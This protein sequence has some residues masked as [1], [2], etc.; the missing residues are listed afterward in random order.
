M[1]VETLQEL[2]V[3]ELK[4][5]YSAEK[6]ITKALPKLAK[7]TTSPELKAAFES[8][9]QETLGQIERL[10]QVFDLLDLPH[11]AKLCHGMQGVLEE[12]S[13]VLEDVEKG[14]LRDAALIGAAQRVEHYEMAG[15][16]CV[17]EYANLLGH[18]DVAKLLAATL[19]EEK[20]ADEKLGKIAKQV[21]TNALRLAA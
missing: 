21:N 9:L 8:H 1:S 3:D 19:A 18:K 14:D 15:Y 10:D 16:G 17:I 7:A 13:E 20:A 6:Q 12:G 11:K 4:D 5:L 2:L